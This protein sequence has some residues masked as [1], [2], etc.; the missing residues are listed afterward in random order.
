MERGG[1]GC[2]GQ[3]R[4]NHKGSGTSK[5]PQRLNR[6]QTTSGKPPARTGL[7]NFRCWLHRTLPSKQVPNRPS[8]AHR[9]SGSGR[10]TSAPEVKLTSPPGRREGGPR[11]SLVPAPQPRGRAN[12]LQVRGPAVRRP[13]RPRHSP[14]AG[15]SPPAGGLLKDPGAH[16]PAR[17]GPRSPADER[18]KQGERPKRS[19]RPQTLTA[20][21]KRVPP[22]GNSRAPGAQESHARRRPGPALTG[23]GS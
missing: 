8:S 17:P 21:P 10:R 1:A 9:R 16:F 15:R 3:E 18:R 7:G 12:E 2:Q 13:C 6:P 14:H 22:A 20:S 23:G 11:E 4:N 19:R 5:S